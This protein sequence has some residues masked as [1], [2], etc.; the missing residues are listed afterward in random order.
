MIVDQ[1]GD[2]WL[3]D[4]S[5]SEATASQH[6]MA[7]DV[8]ELLAAAS[9]FAGV[10]T[11]VETAATVMGRN[12]LSSAEELLEPIALSR[13]TRTSLRSR[14]GTLE[15][16][17]LVV[18]RMTGSRRS[19]ARDTRRLRL[20]RWAALLL[21]AGAL[22]LLLATVAGLGDVLDAARSLGWRWVFVA[23]IASG[24]ALG[25]RAVARSGIALRRGHMGEA[26][27]MQLPMVGVRRRPP[28]VRAAVS[29][30]VAVAV[31]GVALT[32]AVAATF[33]E[34]TRAHRLAD[35]WVALGGIGLALASAGA[36]RSLGGGRWS[37][38]AALDALREARARHG[39]LPVLAIGH[40]VATSATVLG[41]LAVLRAVGAD[42]PA[43][44]ASVTLLTAGLLGMVGRIPGGVGVLEPIALVFLVGFGAEAA[45]AVLGVVVYQGLFFWIPAFLRSGTRPRAA[46]EPSVPS[47]EASVELV[48]SLQ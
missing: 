3:V 14:P 16:L 19:V 36:L 15:A 42:V 2:P 39:S 32:L 23:A 35:E 28:S 29:I 40:S 4:F 43:G 8:A 20:I 26:L 33:V 47:G 37:V 34:N 12:V 6:L 27:R 21:G 46:P 18:A 10:R 44:A 22:Y 24:V 9:V 7:H 41:F 11:A 25:G 48:D 30:V 13:A 1:Q 45:P 17:R 38:T 5:Y 31:H